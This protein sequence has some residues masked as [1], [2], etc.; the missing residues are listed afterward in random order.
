[1]QRELR[2]A[3]D[4][5]NTA[6]YGGD[7]R[8]HCGERE[9]AHIDADSV[10]PG[11]TLGKQADQR[12]YADPGVLVLAELLDVT[13]AG[14]HRLVPAVH[15]PGVGVARPGVERRLD[16]GSRRVELAHGGE[17]TERPGSR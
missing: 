11:N 8:S 13:V 3:C 12:A 4:R 10:Q 17:P 2:K 15:H 9:D 16:R 7:E 5:E 6:R 1:M 14:R